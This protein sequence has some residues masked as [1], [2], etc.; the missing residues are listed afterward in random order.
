M[1]R[2]RGQPRIAL[3]DRGDHPPQVRHGVDTERGLRGVRRLPGERHLDDR[4]PAVRDHQVQPCRLADQAG[5]RQPPIK[6]LQHSLSPDA[7]MLLVRDQRQHD[8]PRG[9]RSGG[10]LRRSDHRGH[11]GL[12]VTRAP[13]QQ[14]PAGPAAGDTPGERLVHP[15]DAHG[16]Q[17]PV[18][19]QAAPSAGPGM[20]GDQARP[21]RHPRG[22]HFHGEPAPLKPPR[23]QPGHR[24]LAR[25]PRHQPRVNAVR[26]HQLHCQLDGR[27]RRCAPAHQP[28]PPRRPAAVKIHSIGNRAVT[29]RLRRPSG[30]S[31]QMKIIFNG[32]YVASA[33]PSR[34]YAGP[35]RFAPGLASKLI[36]WRTLGDGR[37]DG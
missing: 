31:G 21:A 14:P 13:A 20:P 12:H 30:M 26:A 1:G 7:G 24:S 15:G 11:P 19:Q 29:P 22:H 6:E 33:A 35:R 23:E 16:V 34:S 8:V 18:Q 4:V 25:S 17:V 36:G 5:V 37:A 2:A 9:P 28:S 27:L 10:R 3:L 32:G